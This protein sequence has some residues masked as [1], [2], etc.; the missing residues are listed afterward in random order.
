MAIETVN[1]SLY[2]GFVQMSQVGGSLS[3]FV[4]H[5]ECLRVDQP[6]CINH[7]FAFYR[8]YRIDDDSDSTRGE[9]FEGLLCVDVDGR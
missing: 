9:L 4:T 6:K 3:W 5:H 7:N 2:G 8:L 1:K